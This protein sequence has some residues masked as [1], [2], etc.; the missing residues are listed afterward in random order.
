MSIKRKILISVIVLV[1]LG[2]GGF[3]IFNYF[4]GG[5]KITAEP[6]STCQNSSL[7]TSYFGRPGTNIT[8]YNLFGNEVSV[9]EKIVPYLDKVQKQVSDAKI[10]YGFPNV[11]TLNIR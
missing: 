1:V 5:Y 6:S 2:T 11:Q 7:I 10:D 9:N 3:F 8:T 4:F